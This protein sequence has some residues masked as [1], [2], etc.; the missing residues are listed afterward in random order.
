MNRTPDDGIPGGMLRPTANEMDLTDYVLALWRRRWWIVGAA[1]ACAAVAL[2]IGLAGGRTYQAQMTLIVS[3]AKLDDRDKEPRPIEAVNFK[4]Y[5]EGASVT[6]DVARALHLDTAPD[7]SVEG[8]R[9]TN[10]LR[11]TVQYSDPQVAA[12]F[13]NRV[14]EHGVE[15]ARKVN[16]DQAVEARDT[17]KDQLD[18]QRALLDEAEAKLKAYRDE[19]QIEALENDVSAALDRR[20]G[21]SERGKVPQLSQLY[22]RETRLRRLEME[23]DFA[24]RM[25][26]DIASR[27]QLA[28]VQVASRGAQLQIMDRAVAPVAPLPRGIK[29]NVA[30]AGM[31]GFCLAVVI[32]L[33]AQALQAATR[34]QAPLAQV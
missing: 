5:L 15:S 14:A 17:I 26:L 11:L 19:A 6:H 29:R 30:L 23:R 28:R 18:Q 10:L 13:A 2:A 21:A 32:V 24:E 12:D 34:R 16:A 22:E 8:V 3:E 4:P 25:Y 31:L 1:V 20:R 27:Y 9:A 33:F 7:V